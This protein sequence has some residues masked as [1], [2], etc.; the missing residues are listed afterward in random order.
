MGDSFCEW[1]LGMPS[2]IEVYSP[3]GAL[4]MDGAGRY[5]RVIDVFQPSLTG[6]ARSYPEI[7]AQMLDFAYF[8]GDFQVLT[9]WKDQDTIRWRADDSYYAGGFSGPRMLVVLA[10]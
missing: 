4:I 1:G 6:G 3:S 9:V 7:G 10:F 8:Q 2:G 5:G